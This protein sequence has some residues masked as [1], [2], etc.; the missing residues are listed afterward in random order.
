MPKKSILLSPDASST[1]TSRIPLDSRGLGFSISGSGWAKLAPLSRPHSWQLFARARFIVVH[2]SHFHGAVSSPLAFFFSCFSA[3]ASALRAS[4]PSAKYQ[5]ANSSLHTS[6]FP[7]SS[8]SAIV[9]SMSI[10]SSDFPSKSKT[11]LTSSRSSHPFPSTSTFSHTRSNFCSFSISSK[12]F[13]TT[14]GSS[15]V[16]VFVASW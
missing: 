13:V 12:T 8:S 11:A 3:F 9:A 10:S 14:S 7:S 1:I 5:G 6:W 2:T 16:V 15:Q 4:S